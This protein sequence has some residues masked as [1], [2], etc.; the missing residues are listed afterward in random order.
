MLSSKVTCFVSF[1][2]VIPMSCPRMIFPISRHFCNKY[3]LTIYESVPDNNLVF[4]I[5][6][7]SYN[8]KLTTNF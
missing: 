5:N 1:Y 8:A 2:H 4:I 6:V 3:N 7:Y